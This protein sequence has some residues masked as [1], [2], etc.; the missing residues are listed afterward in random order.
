MAA[1]TVEA[2]HTAHP[3]AALDHTALTRLPGIIYQAVAN[4]VAE[5][6]ADMV[7]GSLSQ[8][9]DVRT[10]IRW[11]TGNKP[12]L[13]VLASSGEVLGKT[14]CLSVTGTR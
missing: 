10:S 4:G 12:A 6:Q 3:T 11:I 9:G 13:T 5:I 2:V 1:V 7:G 8:A 14:I